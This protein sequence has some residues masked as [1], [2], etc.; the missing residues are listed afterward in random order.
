MTDFAAKYGA[1]RP[2]K[3]NPWGAIPIKDGRMDP[4]N[5]QWFPTRATAVAYAKKLFGRSY[6]IGRS[7]FDGEDPN[8][9]QG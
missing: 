7:W 9:H 8:N 6:V 3:E 1:S 4:V 5:Q 2:S